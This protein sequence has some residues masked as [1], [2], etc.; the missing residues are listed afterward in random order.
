MNIVVMA[1]HPDDEALGCG[2]TIYKHSQKGDMVTVVF[3][4]YG[5][6]ND[7]NDHEF[8]SKKKEHARKSCKI[9]GVSEVIFLGYEGA[10]LDLVSKSKLN[11]HVT[12][13]IDQKKADIVYTHHWGDLNSDHRSVFEATM[14]ACRPH[15]HNGIRVKEVLS[16]EV[17]SS[18]EWDGKVGEDFFSPTKYIILTKDSMLKKIAAFECYHT[19]QCL[20][21]HPRSVESVKNLMQ[22]RGFNV[23]AE[24]AEA[25]TLVRSIDI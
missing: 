3:V 5:H 13:V 23:N 9:L 7:S 19:E 12:K 16:Y 17:L 14:V 11:S 8:I 20:Y 15:K 1:A 10:N 4:T 22:Y 24:Y 18:S 6:M 25:Y 2:G 21:P